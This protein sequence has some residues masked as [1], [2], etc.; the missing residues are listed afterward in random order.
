[1]FPVYLHARKKIKG[2]IQNRNKDGKRRREGKLKGK[3]GE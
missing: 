1:V 3:E 2:Q